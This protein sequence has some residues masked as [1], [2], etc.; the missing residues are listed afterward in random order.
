MK[1]WKI[2]FAP[3]KSNHI[4]IAIDIFWQ[5]LTRIVPDLVGLF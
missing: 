1:E 2:R 5:T 3:Q 4:L